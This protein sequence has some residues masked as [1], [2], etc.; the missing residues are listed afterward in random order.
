M[1]LINLRDI[2][3]LV[4]LIERA[5]PDSL[6]AVE[7]ILKY[8]SEINIIELESLRNAVNLSLSNKTSR[9]LSISVKNIKARLIES[10]LKTVC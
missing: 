10:L 5:T 8:N 3:Q 4:E 6:N 2:E 9:E 1:K 7:A